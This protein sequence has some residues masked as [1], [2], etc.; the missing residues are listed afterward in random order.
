MKMW[1]SFFCWFSFVTAFGQVE[2]RVL[3]ES[4]ANMFTYSNGG[5]YFKDESFYRKYLGG[6]SIHSPYSRNTDQKPG[7]KYYHESYK[8]KD[9]TIVSIDSFNDTQFYFRRYIEML[10]NDS[11]LT[12]GELKVNFSKFC[13]E[14]IM[15]RDYHNE[16]SLALDTLYEVEAIGTWSINID[17]NSFELGEYSNGK[18]EGKWLVLNATLN[19]CYKDFVKVERIYQNGNLLTEVI[20]DLSLTASLLEQQK[21]IMCTWFSALGEHEFIG[22]NRNSNKSIE[23]FTSDS[24]KQVRTTAGLSSIKFLANNTFKGTQRFRC[25]TGRTVN[26]YR[27]NGS[28]EMTKVGFISLNEEEYK[29]EYLTRSALVLT[30]KYE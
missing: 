21:I 6:K 15:F 30:R 14:E 17:S 9:S 1:V 28:W 26:D 4:P 29:I 24:L 8:M 11:I 5:I 18:K 3:D 19:K 13:V 10:G 25:G 27:P 20:V 12:E 22:L 16:D 2:Q 23:V 7:F